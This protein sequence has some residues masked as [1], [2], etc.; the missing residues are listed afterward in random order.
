MI[1]SLPF[2]RLLRGGLLAALVLPSVARAQTAPKPVTQIPA[3]STAQIQRDVTK[4][5]PDPDAPKSKVMLK[6]ALAPE[7]RQTLQDAMNSAPAPK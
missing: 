4:T 3:G 1:M 2:P 7:T 5:A 6:D